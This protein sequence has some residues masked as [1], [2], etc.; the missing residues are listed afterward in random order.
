MEPFEKKPGPPV[1]GE[2]RQKP[3]HGIDV[4][5]HCSLG[6]ITFK[7]LAWNDHKARVVNI[8]K[9]GVGIEC[10]AR[11]EPGFV[12]FKDRVAGFKGG[13]LLWSRRHGD[14][15]RAGIRFLAL[16]PRDEQ[17]LSGYTL[18]GTHTPRRTPEEIVSTLLNSLINSD[19]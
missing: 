12:L 16:S 4:Q 13:V 6:L 8:S 10:A 5:R 19:S 18:P 3:R 7:D 14:R 15:Y 9:N 11:I 17:Y 2:H 1:P